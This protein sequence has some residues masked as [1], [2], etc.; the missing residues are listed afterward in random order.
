MK[1]RKRAIIAIV[2]LS[3][4][5][6]L[7]TRY[8]M[9]MTEHLP[10]RDT[11]LN[12]HTLTTTSSAS[13][14]RRELGESAAAVIAVD[15][16]GNFT[17]RVAQFNL[18]L[19]S[20]RYQLRLPA[21]GSDHE[22]TSCWILSGDNQTANSGLG[23]GQLRVVWGAKANYID[24]LGN[25]QDIVTVV[26]PWLR[27][28]SNWNSVAD[29][30]NVLYQRYFDWTA[31]N[32]LCSWIEMPGRL[33]KP[34]NL[35]YRRLCNRNINDTTRE[36]SLRPLYLN[37]RP[38]H[39]NSYTEQFYTSAPPYVFHMHIHRNAVV[40]RLGD[41]ITSSTKLILDA[42]G[43]DGK[44]TL[45]LG[46]KLS[47]IP[48][49]DEVYVITQY[50]GNGVFHRMV[51]IVPRL[52]I[53]LEFLKAHKEI[54]ILAP[55][56]GGRTA[57]LLK[58][59]GLDKSRLVSGIA[60]ANIVYQPRS[61]ACGQANVQES[62]I[63]SQLYRDYMKRTF[64]PQPRNRL[65]LIRRSRSRK[66]SEQ[67]KIE[68]VL[69]RTAREYNLT[70]TLF[71]DNPTPSLSDTMML[72]HSAVIIVAPHGGGLSNMFFSHPGTFVV[73]GVCNSPHI[74]LCYQ[75]LAHILG[76]HWHGVTSRGGCLSY[77]NV[78]ARKLEDAVRS[79]LYSGLSKAVFKYI[80]TAY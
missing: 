53:C 54:R 73:E 37:V 77:V 21:S 75:R 18:E 58:I 44:R 76:H 5:V 29:F 25:N 28:R 41:V 14:L 47:N 16:D 24:E 50:W 70:Y 4:L 69:E 63:V 65:I 7:A 32:V 26:L 9:S 33:I 39:N 55:Q 13:A 72:F 11:V 22:K 6:H 56:V 36:Q 3:L 64:R 43:Y 62:Q 19:Q 35:I 80:N 27:S 51:E 78:S 42:C 74:N 67:R 52:A 66:F 34:Y 10:L 8:Y 38:K 45:P 20:L 57:K 68:V 48:C 30:S 46:S 71:K 61:T 31:D 60:L 40:T 2:V 59:I 1:T 49:Y 17:E 15:V 79:Y 12:T 23:V